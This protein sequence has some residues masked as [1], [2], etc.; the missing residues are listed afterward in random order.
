MSRSVRR[1]LK[2][3]VDPLSIEGQKRRIVFGA[4]IVEV[5][6]TT[7]HAIRRIC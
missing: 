6:T 7:V 2:I 1:S 4:E 5:S 3:R